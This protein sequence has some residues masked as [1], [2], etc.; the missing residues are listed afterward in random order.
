MSMAQGM[1]MR[2]SYRK[3]PS[4]GKGEGN[5]TCGR[6]SAGQATIADVKIASACNREFAIKGFETATF[7]SGKGTNISGGDLSLEHYSALGVTTTCSN[8]WDPSGFALFKLLGKTLS[9]V[10]DLSK[11]GCACNLALYL[12]NGPPRDETGQPAVGTCSWGPYYCDSSS[13]CGEQCP[14]VDLMEAN[15]LA[16]QATP[17]KCDAPSLSGR[18]SSCDRKGCSH[19]TAS[20]GARAYGP[21]DHYRINTLRPFEVHTSFHEASRP[22]GRVFAGMTT[23]LRQGHRE[24]VLDHRHCSSY[25]EALTAPLLQGMILRVSYWGNR[26]ST[27]AWLDSP[28]CGDEDRCDGAAAGKA[29]IGNITISDLDSTSVQVETDGDRGG[30][31]GGWFGEP[32]M[33]AAFVLFLG[34]QCFILS[35]LFCYAASLFQWLAAA[36]NAEVDQPMQSPETSFAPETS[37]QSSFPPTQTL[38]PGQMDQSLGIIRELPQ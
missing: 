6:N 38:R 32:W 26:A 29:A 10:V 35:C 16:F 4:S 22:T 34:A 25:I 11:V 28:A 23:V 33:V 9:F 24:I 27:M 15:S 8:H 17:H 37:F 1:A 18:Y 7:M 30:T 21:A 2:L 14:E 36:L 12:I 20:L 3:M 5:T 19:H 13:V 31:A